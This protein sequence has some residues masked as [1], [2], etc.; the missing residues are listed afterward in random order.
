MVI[1]SDRGE[2]YSFSNLD[3]KSIIKQGKKHEYEGLYLQVT[4]HTNPES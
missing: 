4:L 1:G 2:N 3:N